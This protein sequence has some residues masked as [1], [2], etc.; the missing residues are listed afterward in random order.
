MCFT[1]DTLLLATAARTRLRKILDAEDAAN[2]GASGGGGAQ[3]SGAAMGA[4]AISPHAK[5]SYDA[6][7]FESLAQQYE[8]LKWRMISKPGGAA[9]K[10]E[11]FYK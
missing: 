1:L 9:V 5:S 11:E 4:A 3:S 2:L 7:E 8:G 10:P 6:N